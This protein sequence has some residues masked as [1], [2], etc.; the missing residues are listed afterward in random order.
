[1]IKVLIQENG[2][3]KSQGTEYRNWV[4]WDKHSTSVCLNG[5]FDTHELIAIIRHMEECYTQKH[6][7]N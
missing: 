1:M 3:L 2:N 6:H 7:K 4:E 5:D